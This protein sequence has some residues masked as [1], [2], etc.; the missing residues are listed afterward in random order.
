VALPDMEFAAPPRGNDDM[1]VST[2][3]AAGNS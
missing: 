1:A 2:S 3:G